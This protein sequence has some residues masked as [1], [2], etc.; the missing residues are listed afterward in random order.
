MKKLF[1]LSFV[2][3]MLFS[4][5]A[6]KDDSKKDDD[7]KEQTKKEMIT[8]DYLTGTWIVDDGRRYDNVVV[9]LKNGDLKT[10]NYKDYML[11]GNDETDQMS[12]W[13]LDE[14]KQNII[15]KSG[16]NN[17]WI[18]SRYVNANQFEL[19]EKN[20]IVTLYR[21]GHYDKKKYSKKQSLNETDYYQDATGDAGEYY[22]YNA[23]AESGFYYEDASS[24]AY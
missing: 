6:E 10:F 22:D 15:I 18:E 14:V 13:E 7:E 21:D 12:K 20:E 3:S 4:C 17:I 23:E 19:K 1:Y 2:L 16:N 24:D 11:Y 8:D 9:F 5:G